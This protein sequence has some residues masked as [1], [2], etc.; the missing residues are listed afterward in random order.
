MIRCKPGNIS[1]GFHRCFQDVHLTLNSYC[2]VLA[3]K[4]DA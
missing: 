4:S 2:Q 3:P 1:S